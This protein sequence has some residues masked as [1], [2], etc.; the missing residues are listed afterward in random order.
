MQREQLR[1]CE[2][3]PP[4]MEPL[5][6]NTKLGDLVGEE[7]DFSSLEL[8][9]AANRNPSDPKGPNSIGRKSWLDLIMQ[10]LQVP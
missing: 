7:Q 1:T 8:V 4:E 3:T 2:A 10:V 5:G 6:S 9:E